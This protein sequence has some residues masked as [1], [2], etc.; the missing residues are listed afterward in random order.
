MIRF[1]QKYGGFTYYAGLEPIVFGILHI[2]P[3]RGDFLGNEGELSIE[4]PNENI[5]ENHYVCADTLYQESFTI[6]ENGDY[7]EGH[8][9]MCRLFET[10]IETFSMYDLINRDNAY[11]AVYSYREPD[12]ADTAEEFERI[13]TAFSCKLIGFFKEFPASR[14]D[15]YWDDIQ[16][17]YTLGD[18]ILMHRVN[19]ELKVF[20]RNPKIEKQIDLWDRYLRSNA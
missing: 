6:T 13:I 1:Q 7:Y 2:G 8:S 9:L 20:S 14:V 11:N 12:A 19:L 18:D 16:A 17:W 10:Q 5:K 3:C 15:G 4:E